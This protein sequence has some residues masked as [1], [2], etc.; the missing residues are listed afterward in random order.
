MRKIDPF[1]VLRPVYAEGSLARTD[2]AEKLNVAPSLVGDLIRKALDCE[3]VVEHGSAPSKGGRR[4]ILLQANPEYANLI[5]VDIGRLK[6]CVVVTDFVGAVLSQRSFPTETA[7]GKE[8][9]LA[10]VHE[11]L[12]SQ[13]CRFPRVAAI[14]VTLSGVI[15]P[16]AGT[17]LFWPMVEG[18]DDTPLRQIV[19]DAHGLPTFMVGDDVRAAA[20]TEAR[21]GQGKGLNRFVLLLLGRGIGSAIYLD[22]HLQIGR[23]GLA[24][25]LGHT[26]VDENGDLCSCGN[27][28]CLE[29]CSSASAIIRK[30]RTEL[31]RG[32]TSSLSNEL[33]G[34]WDELTLQAIVAA[35][36]TH[37]RLAERILSEA[38]LHLGTALASVVNLL[39]PEKVILMGNV[40]QIAGEIILRPLLYNLRQRALP[41]A[42][43]DLPV[44]VSQFGEEAPAVGMALTA[45]EGLFR[46]AVAKC[47]WS[48]PRRSER[49]PEPGARS[50][51]GHTA[52]N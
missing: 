16:Q 51:P 20:I 14:G 42:V 7:K 8:H 9:V 25:E 2:L 38:G 4:P 31:E 47:Q 18:W 1:D 22:G 45:G 43:K 29:I 44:V 24:G 52:L 27:R 12:K 33:R 17:V 34:R 28:G 30:V 6:T 41:M 26:T 15:H 19:Q 11:E 36:K 21:F 32:I 23:D 49:S 46:V 40:P 35:A 3:L 39:N 13:I 50:M 10:L 48:E 5:G 37:D